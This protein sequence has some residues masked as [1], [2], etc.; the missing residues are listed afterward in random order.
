MLR[1]FFIESEKLKRVVYKATLGFLSDRIMMCNLNVH[2][3]V[4]LFFKKL[5]SLFGT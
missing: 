1:N 2:N 4:I 5:I 3:K